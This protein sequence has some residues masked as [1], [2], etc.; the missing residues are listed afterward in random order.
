M[1]QHVCFGKKGEFGYDEKLFYIINN[2]L[3]CQLDYL[4]IV[5]MSNE[6]AFNKITH[7]I[8]YEFDH[9]I[10]CFHVFKEAQY[11]LI[12]GKECENQPSLMM[13]VKNGNSYKIEEK[14]T[15]DVK[16]QG[17]VS[18]MIVAEDINRIFLND[19]VSHLRFKGEKVNHR[20]L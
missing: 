1:I 9:P 19:N 14:L 18:Q 6:D 8:V 3:L 4:K 12:G 2:N 11:I 7:E 17:F 16:I 20:L 5:Q 10:L 15:A 13:I